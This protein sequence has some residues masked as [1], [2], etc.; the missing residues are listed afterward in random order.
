MTLG[1]IIANFRLRAFDSVAPYL[2]SDDELREFADDAENESCERA[3]L[4][5]DTTT[6]EIC[7]V[8]VIAGTASYLLD[9]RILVVTRAKLDNTAVPL[10][11]MS[12]EAMDRTAG[13]MPRD[14]RTQSRS[15]MADV[16]GGWEQRSG[17]PAVALLDPEGT[18]WKLT[19]TPKPV[20][21]DTLRLQVFRL[22]I[23][24]LSIDEGNVPEIPYRLHPRLVDWMMY[25]AY[26][27][28]D[29]ETKDTVKAAQAEAA[30]AASFG[31]RVDA[32][33][34]RKQLD[35]APNVTVFREF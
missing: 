16:G 7:N 14:W 6:P 32:N 10:G 23:G 8:S 31:P 2:W 33:V 15:W 29:V 20:V 4:L 11:L 12:T 25:R 30:F 26:S 17:T 3:Y 13:A 18:R 5:R 19:L 9:S 1:E 34:R 21:N 28:Q 35:R 24:P 22:P 27:K